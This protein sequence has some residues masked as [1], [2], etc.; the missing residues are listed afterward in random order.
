MF[1]DAW[2]RGCSACSFFCDG[3][4]GTLAHLLPR[5]SM[6]AVAQARPE[7]LAALAK[8]KG[9]TM[10]FYSSNNSTFNQVW[11]ICRGL[12]AFNSF[13]FL[14]LKHTY[15]PCELKPN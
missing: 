2:D 13:D 10:P 7:K 4:N 11:G 14:R 15:M 6:C 1:D 12:L 3:F 5:A 8:T 9:W